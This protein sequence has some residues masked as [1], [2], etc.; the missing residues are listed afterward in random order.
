[1]IRIIIAILL[2]SSCGNL[3]I[4]YLQNFSSV[5][6]VVFGFPEYEIT[7]EIFDEFENSFLKIR[8][9]RGPH[10][11][12]ILAYVDNDIYEWVGADDVSI[13]TKNGRIIKTSGLVHN[14]EIIKPLEKLY[15]S[16]EAYESLN[17]L[18]PD[19]FSATLKH[20]ISIDEKKFT[21]LGNTINVNRIKDNITLDIIG[22][23]KQDIY[24]QNIDTQ[25]IEAIEQNIHPELPVV[26][27][28]YYL[29][30]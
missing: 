9:G 19:L 27:V 28:E 23:Q 16:N 13:F 5:N 30:F 25:Q 12:L 1:M 22:W 17:L 10:A 11:I 24:Y 18:N 2:L 3:P 4:A 29:K 14:L 21:K 6:N 7:Q 20:S 15:T 26:K 8:F